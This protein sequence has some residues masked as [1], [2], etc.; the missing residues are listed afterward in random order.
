MNGG[1]EEGWPGAPATGTD[2]V[3]QDQDINTGSAPMSSMCSRLSG[4]IGDRDEGDRHITRRRVAIM[5]LVMNPSMVLVG[6]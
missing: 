5:E 3:Y 4:Q 6:E 2:P 1:N